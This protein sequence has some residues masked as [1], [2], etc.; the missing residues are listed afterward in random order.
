M[1]DY[2]NNYRDPKSE[3]SIYT[4]EFSWAIQEYSS[5]NSSRKIKQSDISN[6][7]G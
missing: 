5:I 4:R 1:L 2:K 3:Y 6:S 7:R